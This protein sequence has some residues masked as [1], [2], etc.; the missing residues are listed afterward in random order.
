MR[1]NMEFWNLSNTIV[2]NNN[3]W[4]PNFLFTEIIHHNFEWFPRHVIS[5][6]RESIFQ[7]LKKCYIS[8]IENSAMNSVIVE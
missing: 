3:K 1:C 6:L 7:I 8:Q 4:S 5:F 2:I